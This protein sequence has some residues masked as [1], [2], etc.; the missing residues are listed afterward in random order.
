MLNILC[1]NLHDEV[2]NRRLCE[3]VLAAVKFEQEV[4][5]DDCCAVIVYKFSLKVTLFVVESI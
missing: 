3:Q 1:L 2:S 4:F 5:H